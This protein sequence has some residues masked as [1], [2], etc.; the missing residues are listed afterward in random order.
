MSLGEG[1]IVLQGASSPFM[2]INSG[3][4]NQLLVKTDGTDAFMTMGS[5]TSFAHEGSGTAGILIG[6]DASNPQA[7][8]VKSSTNYFIFDGASGVDIK[9]T[10]LELDANDGDLQL[11]STI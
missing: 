9:T 7:E 5:K 6:M 4:A 2:A 8:F 10:A 3:S 11:S 1:K